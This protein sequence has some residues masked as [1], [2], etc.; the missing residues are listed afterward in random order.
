M[1]V[2]PTVNSE[3]KSIVGFFYFLSLTFGLNP[4]KEMVSSFER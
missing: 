2:T 1:V 3:V 4:N